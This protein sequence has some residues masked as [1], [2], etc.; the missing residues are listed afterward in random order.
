MKYAALLLAAAA[1]CSVA[2]AGEQAGPCRDDVRQYCAQ[3]GGPKPTMDCLLD[4]QKDISDACYEKL[5][6]RMDNQAGFKACKQDSETLCKG[7]QPGGGRIINCLMDHQK[8]VSD[9]C[10]DALAKMT[11]AKGKS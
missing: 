11:K 5:K 9:G 6:Q 4:H 10:Y 8:E 3:A 1:V 7:V 2:L